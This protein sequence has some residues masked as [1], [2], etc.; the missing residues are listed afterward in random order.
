MHYMKQFIGN[1][2]D[3]VNGQNVCYELVDK[4]FNR[5]FMTTCSWTGLSRS[6][7]PKIGLKECTNILN[8]FFTI[9]KNVNEHFSVKAM[10]EFL[11]SVTR[12]A[13][14]R[15]ELKNIRQSAIKRR[16]RKLPNSPIV[17]LQV[18]NEQVIPL[19]SPL[20]SSTFLAGMYIVFFVKHSLLQIVFHSR[21][22]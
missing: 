13:K 16:G 22:L 8:V 2:G 1:T 12:N 19:G 4:F 21:I 6:E 17:I 10:E 5:Q 18:G 3:T 20:G 11:K 14:K 9:V 7:E 15:S